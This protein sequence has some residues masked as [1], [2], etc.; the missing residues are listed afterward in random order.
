MNFAMLIDGCIQRS[1]FIQDK[2]SF[3]LKSDELIPYSHHHSI[4]NECHLGIWGWPFVFDGYFINWTEW[5]ELPS[6]DLDVVMVAIEKDPQKYNVDMLR[7]KYPNATV[8]SFIKEDYWTNLQVGERIDFFKSCDVVTFPWLIQKDDDGILGVE[9]LTKLCG[10]D[11]YYMPQPHDID[12]LY[13][14]YFQ[15]KKNIQILNYKTPETSPGEHTEDFVNHISKKYNIHV[16]QHIVKYKGPEH[17][18]WEEFL[19]GITSSLYCFNLDTVRTGGSMA[20]QCAA[21]GILNVGGVQ[22]SHEILYPET[23]T[24]DWEQL[25]NAFS[26]IHTNS[27]KRKEVMVRAFEKAKTHYSHNAVKQK[28]S[29]LLGVT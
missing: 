7:K 21:L 6:L 12:F 3:L 11:V 4:G 18:Q 2:K 26:E 13:D 15:S 5:E 28:F 27:E 20:V 9:N 14:R 8:V 19:S 16:M 10:K 24:N 23:A 25:E 22:D 29:S 17:N 1:Y